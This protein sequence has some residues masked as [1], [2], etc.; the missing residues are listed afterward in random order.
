MWEELVIELLTI[1]V[2]IVVV[3][4]GGFVIQYIKSKIGEEKLKLYLSYAKTVVTSV[5]QTIGGGHG[6]D[7]KQEAVQALKNI[8]KGKL[9]DEQIDRLIEAAVYEMNVLLKEHKIK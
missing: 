3:A 6:V 5:E 4:V 2:Q 7:K 1:L 9:S 8:T